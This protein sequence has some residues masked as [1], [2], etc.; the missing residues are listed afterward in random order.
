M[1]ILTLHQLLHMR[2][3]GFLIV[4]DLL[5]EAGSIKID[6]KICCLLDFYLNS[7]ANMQNTRGDVVAKWKVQ[8]II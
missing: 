4:N 8:S 2:H 6:D 5:P 7:G 3:A 1:E